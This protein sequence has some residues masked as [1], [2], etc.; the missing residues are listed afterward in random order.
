MAGKIRRL[1]LR[2]LLDEPPRMDA[3]TAPVSSASGDS[4]PSPLAHLYTAMA[5]LLRDQ[6]SDQLSSASTNDLIAVGL[7]AAN[8]A[9]AV[10]LVILRAT[11]PLTLNG[12]WYHW[13]YPLPVLLVSTF[14]VGSPLMPPF[15]KRKF[16]DGPKV[17]T[18]L[19]AASG[20]PLERALEDLLRALQVAWNRNDRLLWK[21]RRWFNRG[22]FIMAVASLVSIGSYTWALR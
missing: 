2:W 19:R 16:Q 22:L 21:E 7:V 13:W 6:V 15:G 11:A 20:Q 17:E 10:G 8:L 12:W 4:N 9:L 3:P 14:M 18:L 1:V 5:D